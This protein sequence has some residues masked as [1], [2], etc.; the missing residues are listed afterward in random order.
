LRRSK[1]ESTGEVSDNK[2][3]TA[4][5]TFL[6]SYKLKYLKSNET[7]SNDGNKVKT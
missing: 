5:Q 6:P 3:V 2:N 7:E 4:S 1:A